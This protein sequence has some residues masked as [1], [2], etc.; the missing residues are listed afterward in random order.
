MRG[1]FRERLITALQ[2]G[3]VF[4][5]KW[6]VAMMFVLILA[7]FVLQDYWTI[8]LGAQHGEAAFSYLVAQQNAAKK[9][10]P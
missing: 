8:R 9:P 5:A 3:V 6:G 7:A 4:G 1:T 10:T 2:D